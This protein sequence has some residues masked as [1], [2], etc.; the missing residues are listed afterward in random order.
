MLRAAAHVAGAA[1]LAAVVLLYT[2]VPHAPFTRTQ[3]E[4]HTGRALQGFFSD[5]QQTYPSGSHRTSAAFISDK[6]GTTPGGELSLV[7]SDDGVTFWTLHGRFAD[8]QRLCPLG[9]GLG[10]VPPHPHQSPNADCRTAY[11]IE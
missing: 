6:M 11:P 1:F 3:L 10:L 4:P 2:L 7:G 5:W 9:L 8:A